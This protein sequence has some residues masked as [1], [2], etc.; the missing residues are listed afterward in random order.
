MLGAC[1]AS[2]APSNTPPE[3]VDPDL[4]QGMISRMAG[5]LIGE[6]TTQM[7][8]KG[9][10]EAISICADRA[11][12]M[13]KEISTEQLRLR[14]IGTRPRNTAT[15][16]PTEGERAVLAKLTKESPIFQGEVD[17]KQMFL[18]AQFIPSAMCLTCHGTPEQV[19][20]DV[21]EA[22]AKRYPD[23]QAMGYAVG[24]LRGALIVERK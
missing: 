8:E 17:G 15:N 10:V 11:P 16:T 18:R 22:L 20:R 12:E 14:R 24:D 4:A 6:L 9:P 23:D 13:A 1:G 7:A 21:Q 19:P 3:A 2:E 5:T